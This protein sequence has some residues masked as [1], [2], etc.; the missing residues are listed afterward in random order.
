[1]HSSQVTRH[2]REEG[3]DVEEARICVEVTSICIEVT[4]CLGLTFGN[5]GV[6]SGETADA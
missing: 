4:T 5:H 1:M 3:S 6:S 2:E